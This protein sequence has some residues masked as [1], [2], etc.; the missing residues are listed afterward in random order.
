MNLLTS[1]H[2][3]KQK[4][5]DPHGLQRTATPSLGKRCY[6]TSVVGQFHRLVS[7]N[8]SQCTSRGEILAVVKL[9]QIP[10]LGGWRTNTPGATRRVPE[11]MT[12]IVPQSYGERYRQ[13]STLYVFYARHSQCTESIGPLTNCPRLAFPV[14][15]RSCLLLT[16]TR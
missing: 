14:C 15:S 10:D 9:Q 11:C 7:S 16:H 12:V 1:D 4:L 2:S 13:H 8:C 6:A 5:G 3:L